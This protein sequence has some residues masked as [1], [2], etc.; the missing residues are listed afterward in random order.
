VLSYCDW[1]IELGPG[2]GNNGGEIIAQGSPAD[3][4]RNP[5]SITG[6]FLKDSVDASAEK[7]TEISTEPSDQLGLFE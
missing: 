4:K 5:A 1:I 7:S 2:G 3:L 6:P